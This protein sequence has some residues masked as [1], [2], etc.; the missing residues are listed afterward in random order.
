MR[1]IKFRQWLGKR[2]FH[3][4]GFENGLCSGVCEAEINKFPIAQF[5]GLHDKNGVEI[6][7]G[8]IYTDRDGYKR[9]VAFDDDIDCDGLEKV[10]AGWFFPGGCNLRIIGNIHENPELLEGKE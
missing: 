1:E 7:E 9:V 4:F 6:Y 5:T 2:G 3:Y 8:D 10:C